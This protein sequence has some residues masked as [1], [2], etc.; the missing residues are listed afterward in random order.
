MKDVAIL[1]N[2]TDKLVFELTDPLLGIISADKPLL[3]YDQLSLEKFPTDSASVRRH[4]ERLASSMRNLLEARARSSEDNDEKIRLIVTIDLSGRSLRPNSNLRFFPAQQVRLFID[5][6]K[7]V[8]REDN[9]LIRRFEYS[10]IFLGEETDDEAVFYQLLAHDGYSGS[11][12]KDWI[13]RDCVCLNGLRDETILKLDSPDSESPLTDDG[14]ATGYKSFKNQ[15]DSVVEKVAEQMEEAG[16]K[17]EFLSLLRKKMEGVKTVGDLSGFDFDGAILSSVSQLIGLCSQDFRNDCV[18]FLLLASKNTVQQLHNYETYVASLVQFLA[19]ISSE[20][21]DQVLKT[22]LSNAS[23]RLFLLKGI[24][25]DV[26]DAESLGLLERHVRSCLP[27]LETAKW[28]QDKKVEYLL[29]SLNSEDPE[30]VDSHRELNDKLSEERELLF[31]SFVEAR[32]VP[33]FFGSPVGDWKWYKQVVKAAEKLFSFESLND[34]PLYDPPKRIADQE[35]GTEVQECSYVELE[36]RIATQIKLIPD[37]PKGKGLNVYLRERRIQMDKLEAGIEGMK[38][39]LVKL[40][41]FTCLLW[42]GIFSMIGFTLNYSYHFFWFDNVDNP[43]LIAVCFGAASLLFVVSAIVGR[44]SV[45]SKIKAAYLEIDRCYHKMQEELQAYLKEVSE[46]A[47]LQNEADVARKNLDEMRSKLDAFQIHN[48][49]V[50]IWKE[51]FKGITTKL[52]EKYRHKDPSLRKAPDILERLTEDDF[53]FTDTVPT[54]PL[55]IRSE[56]ESM[57]TSFSNG[58]ILISG[59]TS[60]VSRFAFSEER[61]N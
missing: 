52:S 2:L 1:L 46:R 11:P 26:I 47:R 28:K 42:I 36:N 60:F 37:L 6:V 50:D 17:N 7:R 32:K 8:F 13:E 25:G 22:N 59:L 53:D 24:S 34:R 49:Q 9:P 56:F 15:L 48:R 54:L 31:T 27:V 35:M 10:F 57:T 39:E 61:N 33:F 38:K 5:T 30:T 19:T 51:H 40:G 3:Y 18:F 21:Y 4:V 58:G 41:Y 44:S 45:K 43:W 16:L 55:V 14:I 12:T 23:A 29:F 20:N